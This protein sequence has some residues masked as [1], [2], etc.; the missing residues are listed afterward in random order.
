[1]ATRVFTVES[2]EKKGPI[3]VFL[4]RVENETFYVGAEL[5]MESKTGD[6][7]PAMVM[8]ILPGDEGPK[9]YDVAEPGRRMK[10]SLRRKDP[11]FPD[12]EAVAFLLAEEV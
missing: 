11:S 6:Q 2:T 3:T 1:M 5:F 7:D 10:L 8:A 9:T 12:E 4:G